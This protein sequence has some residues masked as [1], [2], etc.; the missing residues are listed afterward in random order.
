MKEPTEHQ[1]LFFDKTRFH[2]ILKAVSV[3]KVQFAFQ[4]STVFL[5]PDGSAPSGRGKTTNAW[6]ICALWA[7][8]NHKRLTDL[9]PLGAEKPPMPDR[10]APSR[11]GKAT[12]AWP[13]CALWARKNHQR[14]TDLQTNA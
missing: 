6:R 1:P 7:R 10:S 4:N 11:C 14:L 5:T 2:H 8:K 9:R 13:I 3:K 12:N